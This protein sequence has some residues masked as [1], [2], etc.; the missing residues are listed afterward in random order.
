MEYFY[1]YIDKKADSDGYTSFSRFYP[2]QMEVYSKDPM[3]KAMSISSAGVV[4]GFCATGDI[5]IKFKCKTS[6]KLKMF[7]PVLRQVNINAVLDLVRNLPKRDQKEKLLLDGIDFVV[8][9]KIIA[10]KQPKRGVMEF[11]FSSPDKKKRE[12]KIYFPVI[13]EMEIK[14]LKISGNIEALKKK[15]QILCLGDSI[16]Q[17][18]FSGH[19]S[20]NYVALL[21]EKLDVYAVNQG[22]GGYTYEPESISGLEKM[23]PLKFITV[24][25]GTNDW[26]YKPDINAIQKNIAEYYKKLVSIFPATLIYAIT[27]LWRGDLDSVAASGVPFSRIADII[28]KE[29][30][31]YPSIKLINGLD[32]LP[33]DNSYFAD[34]FLHPSARG[35]NLFIENLVRFLQA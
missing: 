29:T 27:P 25:Y 8:D 26:Y 11:C 12:V 35:F 14:D 30:A 7:L 24:A 5:A 20:Q 13:F 32:L 4:L 1:N 22:I 3:S 19:P 23:P 34:G 9:G 10:T 28:K 18:F 33:Y 6:S 31:A 2:E 15:E 17:G 16:T 21:A